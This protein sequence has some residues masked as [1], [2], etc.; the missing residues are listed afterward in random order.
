MAPRYVEE[1]T[2]CLAT[3]SDVADVYFSTTDQTLIAPSNSPPGLPSTP[4]VIT[5]SA[6]ERRVSGVEGEDAW[7]QLAG[8]QTPWLSPDSKRLTIFA[9]HTGRQVV[10]CKL[11]AS[12]GA[13]SQGWSHRQVQPSYYCRCKRWRSCESQPVALPS[14]EQMRM[15]PIETCTNTTLSVQS[16]ETLST[17]RSCYS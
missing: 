6:E 7:V 15:F 16:W 14:C 3:C 11:A 17:Q 4:G 13:V 12:A 8:A 9:G 5:A 1:G 10:P 2:C